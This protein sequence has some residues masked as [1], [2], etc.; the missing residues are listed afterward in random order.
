MN[1]DTKRKCFDLVEEFVIK[2]G[3]WPEDIYGM[4]ESGF[5]PSDQ[6]TRRVVG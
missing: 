5:P 6:G 4:D 2:A 3:I 1:P